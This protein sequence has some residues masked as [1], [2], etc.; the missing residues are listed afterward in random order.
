MKKQG[1]TFLD[2]RQV[3][4]SEGEFLYELENSF[5]LSPKVSDLILITAKECLLRD[6]SLQEGQK[7]VTLI[8]LEEKS[9]KM[10]EKMEKKKV[11][12]TLEDVIEDSEVLKNYGRK[13]LR[14]LRIQRITEEAIEQGAI[15]SQE[16][17]SHHLSISLRTVKRDMKEI[18]SLGIEVPTRGSLH[19]IGRGQTHKSRIIG[20]YLDGDTYSEIRLKVKH[21]TQAIKRYLETFTKVVMAEKN[22]IFQSGKISLVTGLSEALVREYQELIRQSRKDSL[23]KS[24]LELLIER[25]SYKDEEF[26]KKNIKNYSSPQAAMLKGG[27]I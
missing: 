5:E 23:R 16:D 6:Y 25:N 12:L 1:R 11:R 21:S 24:N 10:L 9:G 4:S 26:V 18:K 2:R 8:S 22:G 15:L 3:K 19:N 20:M 13:A 7:E 14:Q 27:L 17:I